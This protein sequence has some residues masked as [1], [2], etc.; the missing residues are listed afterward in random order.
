ML[1]EQLEG[2]S[3]AKGGNWASI[4]FERG[5]SPGQPIQRFLFLGRCIRA[6]VRILIIRGKRHRPS[7]SSSST[8]GVLAHSW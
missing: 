8:G 2:F 7:P 3:D 5:N 1:L 4:G 6:E